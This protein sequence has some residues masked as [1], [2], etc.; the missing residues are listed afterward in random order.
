MISR[1]KPRRCTGFTLTRSAN[2]GWA[3]VA[4]NTGL[5]ETLLVYPSAGDMLTALRT[6]LGFEGAPPSA[7]A[8]GW[9]GPDP[10]PE[11]TG[12]DENPTL[13]EDPA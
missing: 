1:P 6:M 3:V 5:A 4:Q 11:W 9:D 7:P 8:P 12:D 10:G 13:I 2:D